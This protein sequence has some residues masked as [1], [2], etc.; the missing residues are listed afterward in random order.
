[1][2]FVPVRIAPVNGNAI[3]NIFVRLLVMLNKYLEINNIYNLLDIGINGIIPFSM[4][5]AWC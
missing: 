3:T 1:M 5:C 4:K 2:L